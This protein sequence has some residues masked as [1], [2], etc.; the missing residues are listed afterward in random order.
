MEPKSESRYQYSVGEEER[1]GNSP[2]ERE[3]RK[4][5]IE[6]VTLEFRIERWEVISR[7]A[8]ERISKSQGWQAWKKP[9]VLV[10]LFVP[11]WAELLDLNCEVGTARQKAR[12]PGGVIPSGIF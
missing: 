1:V 12:H 3:A 6:E 11:P 8:L 10:E 7:Q 4:S 9:G 2:W 5:F